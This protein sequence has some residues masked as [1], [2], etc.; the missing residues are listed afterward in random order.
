MTKTLLKYLNE[1]LQTEIASFLEYSLRSASCGD[2]CMERELAAF[3]LEEAEHIRQLMALIA[4][5]GGEVSMSAPQSFP[6]DSLDDFFERSLARE[7]DAIL[8]YTVLLPLLPTEADRAVLQSSIDQE[9]LHREQILRL[10]SACGHS[11][12]RS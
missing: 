11:A 2:P 12:D 10:R 5:N 3:A 8:R 7:D 6:A 9:A 4:R 1:Q